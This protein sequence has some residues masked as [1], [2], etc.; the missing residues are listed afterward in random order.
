MNE[1]SALHRSLKLSAHYRNVKKGTQ[2]D[3]TAELCVGLPAVNADINS[4]IARSTV[5]LTD[6]TEIVPVSFS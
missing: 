1:Q 6:S 2:A 3:R 4:I 5:L